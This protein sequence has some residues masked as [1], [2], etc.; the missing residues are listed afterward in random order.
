RGPDCS[1]ARWPDPSKEQARGGLYI[2]GATTP[3]SRPTPACGP[4]C[5]RGGRLFSETERLT[6]PGSPSSFRLLRAAAAGGPDRGAPSSTSRSM[7]E[8]PGVPEPRLS[9]GMDTRAPRCSMTRAIGWERIADP[10]L[11]THRVLGGALA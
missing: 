10:L 9:P 1:R 7:A 5:P 6:Q 11:Q 4:H 2:R 3:P 8:R